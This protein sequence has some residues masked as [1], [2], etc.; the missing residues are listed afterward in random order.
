MLY[1]D[2]ITEAINQEAA[3][4]DEER[5]RTSVE[6]SLGRPAGEVL[7]SV[8]TAVH[9]FADGALQSDDIALIALVREEGAHTG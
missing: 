8:M 6:R 1:T 5:L 4:F 3:L 9:A 7:D 2:G